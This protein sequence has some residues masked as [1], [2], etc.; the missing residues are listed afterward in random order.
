MIDKR[1]VLG[2]TVN[3]IDE[4]TF[5][6]DLHRAVDILPVHCGRHGL[7]QLNRAGVNLVAILLKAADPLPTLLVFDRFYLDLTQSGGS[8]KYDVIS[9][10]SCNPNNHF[11]YFLPTLST[12]SLTCIALRLMSEVH[13]SPHS[14][15]TRCMSQKQCRPHMRGSRPRLRYKVYFEAILICDPPWNVFLK[16]QDVINIGIQKTCIV[17]C[18]IN[19]M[20]S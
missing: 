10:T 1:R 15:D 5:T 20:Q 9:N 17:V 14:A 8:I 19:A 16:S 6:P 2:F 7:D 11:C 4:V 3:I 12:Q 13:T 18:N